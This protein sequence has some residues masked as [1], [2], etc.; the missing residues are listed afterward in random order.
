V[1]DVENHHISFLGLNS[2]WACEGDDDRN[3]ITLGHP[4]LTTA[5]EKTAFSNRVLLMHHPPVNWLNEEDFRRY[6]E[7]IFANCSLILHGHTHADKALVFKS[8]A[9]SCICLGANASYTKE[10]DWF[11]GF[12]FI[13]VMFE[14]RGTAVKVWPYRLDER[15]RKKFVPDTHRWDGQDGKPYFEL[16]TFAGISPG[17]KPPLP[18]EIPG[19][20]KDWIKR[21][22]STMDID[23]LAKK[24]EVVK[25]DLPEVYI[26]IETKN[27]FYKPDREEKRKIKGEKSLVASLEDS[28]KDLET[29]EPSVIDIEELMGRKKLILLRGD[30]GTGKTTLVKHLA[31]T[32]SHNTCHKSLR[33][34]LPVMV[35]LKDLWLIYS[36]EMQK[37][38]RKII[39]EDL[40]IR[41]LEKNKCKL[42][43]ETVSNYLAH[44]KVLFLMDGL[45]EVPGRLRPDLVDIMAQ[46]QFDNKE[47]R[48]LLTGRPHGISGKA[49]ARFGDDLQDIDPLDD[50]KVKDFITKWFRAVSGRAAGLGEVTAEGMISDIRQHEHISV[51]TRNPLLLTA[52]CILYQDGKRIPDQR[53]DLYNRIIDNLIHRRFHDPAQPGKENETLEFLMALAFENQKK[54]RKTIVIDDAL[55]ILEKTAVRKG[56]K[57]TNYRQRF[58]HMFNEVEPACGLFNRLGSGEIEFTHLT[59][60]EFL[61]AKHMV[62]MDIDWQPFLEKEWWEETLLLYAG[63]MSIDRKRTANDILETILAFKRKDKNKYSRFKLLAARALCDFQPAKRDETVVSH[64][65]DRLY[66]LLKSD[67]SFQERFQAGVLVGGLGDTRISQDKMVSVPAGEFIRGMKQYTDAEPVKRI[68]LDAFMIGVYPVTNQE[69]KRFIDGNGYHQEEFWPED[70]WQWRIEEKVTEPGLWYDRQWNGPNFPVVGISW[71]EAAAYANWLSK[72]TG[73]SYRLPTEAEWEKAARGTDGEIYPWGN[74]FDKN[75]CNSSE[76]K[77]GRTNPMGIFPGG[78]SSYGCFDM[79]GNVWEWCADWYDENYYKKSPSMNPTGPASGS[80]RVGRGGSW[81]GGAGHCASAF[82]RRGRPALRAGY[83]GVR[84]ARSL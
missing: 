68:F 41:C 78:K 31:Y 69:F 4:Q 21:F 46:F 3:N 28:E 43:W 12:Q 5:V 59:F 37:N 10:K 57:E 49:E 16:N 17:S 76:S 48:F 14:P 70:G 58:L 66:L 30:A 13:E 39:F 38:N 62:Y 8:P 27:P 19:D 32:I 75:L 50:K 64:V 79:A 53:A 84:L 42:P 6:D 9:N 82:R 18:F 34:Y 61:A 33:G 83:L 74:K 20:Y 55:D 11:I 15:G 7:E 73:D 1:K 63:F 65:R 56:E 51:F 29:G 72:E 22:H 71:Y 77:L 67:A 45:D 47:N 81:F 80:G 44:Q 60:Q 54:D 23:L 26:P 35:F 36:E 25:V 52:V 40:L 2:C 24:G